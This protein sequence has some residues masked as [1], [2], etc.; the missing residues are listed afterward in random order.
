ALLPPRRIRQPVTYF[1]S[2]LG[3]LD[4]AAEPR[5]PTF[6]QLWED[7]RQATGDPGL[8]DAGTVA[9]WLAA[10]KFTTWGRLVTLFAREDT[11][12]GIVITGA[13]V[14][15]QIRARA[16][17]LGVD[18]PPIATVG[19]VTRRAIDRLRHRRE[20]FTKVDRVL[21]SVSTI[22]RDLDT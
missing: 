17:E 18:P 4:E 6:T 1:R 14:V 8:V 12:R 7:L 22:A 13:A 5:R 9:D 11:Q 15:E 3:P 10:R 16:V 2:Y 20:Q 21:S 19:A